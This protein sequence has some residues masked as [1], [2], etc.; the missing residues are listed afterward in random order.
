MKLF[1][2]LE[3]TDYEEALRAVGLLLDERGY[4]NFRLVEHEEG[5]VVQAMPTAGGRL[6]SHY[7]T[8]LL[9]DDDILQLL[10]RDSGRRADDR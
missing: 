6:A 7:E 8:F 1:R 5:V 2:G 9:A 3:K 10:K 4:R